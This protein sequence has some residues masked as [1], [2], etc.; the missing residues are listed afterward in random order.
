[1][2]NEANDGS[3]IRPG[4]RWISSSSALG[5]ALAEAGPGT[6]AID[7]E[8]DAQHRYRDRV[9]L[10]QMTIDG[11]DYL[12]DPLEEADLAPL[13]RLLADGGRRKI[14]HGAD[15]DLRM[16]DRDMQFRIEGLFDTMIAARFIGERAF[17]LAALVEKFFGITLDKRF[18]R[19]D[20]SQRPLPAEMAQ[21]AVLD[22]RYLLELTEILETRLK[23]LGRVG[24]ADEEFRRLERVRWTGDREPTDVWQ[25]FKHLRTYSPREL[26]ILRE[27]GAWREKVAMRLDQPPFRVGREEVLATLARRAPR[28]G[29][30]LREVRGLHRRFSSGD[31]SRDLLEAIAIGLER[32]EVDP[33]RAPRGKKKRLTDEQQPELRRLIEIRDRNAAELDLEPPVVAPR[34]LLESMAIAAEQGRPSSEIPELRE[35]QRSLFEAS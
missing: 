22:T 2:T 8:A 18:Q 12:I 29:S 26:S 20:W 25:R 17:G 6:V 31:G 32:A 5:E 35:W 9:C 33:P 4:F 23:E 21:Y 14:F 30:D 28:S 24:W 7:T 34:S 13:G 10:I 15:Y 3:T 19:A 27:L 11:Q 16:L 1:M